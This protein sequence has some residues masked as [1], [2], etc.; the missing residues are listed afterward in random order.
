MKILYLHIGTPKTATT[1]IQ[2]FCHQNGK[3]LEKYG[4]CYPVFSNTN[5]SETRNGHFLLESFKDRD[6]KENSTETQLYRKKHFQ[7]IE[8]LFQS[9]DN[10]IL[11]D[12][13]LWHKLCGVKTK[14]WDELKSQ[15]EEGGY[16][17]K[18]IVYLRRQDTFV[19]SWWNQSI[20]MNGR[21]LDESWEDFIKES[22]LHI[23]YAKEIRKIE[24]LIGRENLLVR[25]FEKRHLKNQ[26]IIDDFLDIIGL[27]YEDEFVRLESARNISLLGNTHE[28][29][30]ILNQLPMLD[31]E[32]NDLFK[33]CLQDISPISGEKYH[34][35]MFSKKEAEN[36]LEQFEEGNHWIAERYFPEESES[37][38]D[39][40]MATVDK[41]TKDNDYMQDDM[42]LF[43]GAAI[44]RLSKQIRTLEEKNN[45]LTYNLKHPVRWLLSKVFHIHICQ[46]INSS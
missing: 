27:R 28:I 46:D 10:I 44:L 39:N 11:S 38:F 20:K 41:W 17:L 35:R 45:R 2:F 5:I 30:R 21:V 32:G 31:R 36:F 1:S 8:K 26:D 6:G 37:L 15:S 22:Y 34:S 4:Y 24:A 3:L 25:R 12:E 33:Y 14:L 43:M 18:V 23:D 19:E 40:S 13:A 16:Q 42:I 29:K 7:Q 9:F